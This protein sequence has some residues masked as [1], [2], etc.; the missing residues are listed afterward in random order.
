[1][2]ESLDEYQIIG[3]ASP[4]AMDELW[5]KGWRHFGSQFLRYSSCRYGGQR[6]HVLPLRIDL[7]KFA[8]SRSQRRVLKRGA[9]VQVEFGVAAIDAERET[10]FANHRSRFKEN[11]PDS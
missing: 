7:R 2:S 4:V 8:P 3:R 9:D 10:M 6:V 1:M 5:S 11:V